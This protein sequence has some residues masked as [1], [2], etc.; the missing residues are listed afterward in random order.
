MAKEIRNGKKV[1]PRPKGKSLEEITEM[2][3]DD[4]AFKITPAKP[5]TTGNIKP[6]EGKK[7]VDSGEKTWKEVSRADNSG[8][9]N[10]RRARARKAES[11]TVAA[12]EVLHQKPGATKPNRRKGLYEEDIVVAEGI[13]SLDDWDDEELIR[14][15]RRGRNGKFGKPPKFIAKEI[16]QEVFRRIVSRGDKRMRAAYL[17]SID[18]LTELAH[19]S[20]SDKVKLE[21]IKELMNRVV[22][23]VPDRVHVA[24]EQPW[25]QFLADSIQPV[26]DEWQPDPMQMDDADEIAALPSPRPVVAGED[27]GGIT[28]AK[29]SPHDE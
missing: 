25:E 15:Y 16:Q 26:G 21:A 29:E 11:V 6:G 17:T 24:Q 5:R 28:G 19:N 23:K 8:R 1:P 27:Y 13:V 9:K 10:A 20:T 12:V 18:E 4:P 14:G 3:P 7:L 2:D 22:G